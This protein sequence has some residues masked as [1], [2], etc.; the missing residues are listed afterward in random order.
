[1]LWPELD[2]LQAR[3]M[4]RSAL[5]MLNH[6]IGKRW[7]SLFEDQIAVP[8]QPGLWIDVVD[9]RSFLAAAEA[10]PHMAGEYC[11]AC[12]NN[13]AAATS[14]AQ[15]GFLEGFMLP[16]AP[17]F[18]LWR[19]GEAAVLQREL[20]VALERL[21]QICAQNGPAHREAAMKYAQQWLW[22]DPLHEP[23]HRAL[24]KLYTEQGDRAAALHQYEDCRKRLAAGLGITP[25]PETTAL[26]AAI[27]QG[28]SLA[29]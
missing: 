15:D 14:L 9:F 17:D 11:T 24:M 27:S 2:Q 25:S 19:C 18:D 7:F 16:D 26:F 5:R 1:M 23:P 29:L 22:L 3:A 21:V 13:F 4:V 6:A 12:L 10:H 20:S 28:C 8:E